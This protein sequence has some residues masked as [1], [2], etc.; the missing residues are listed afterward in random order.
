MTSLYLGTVASKNDVYEIHA[1]T[2][3]TPFRKFTI[4]EIA[5]KTLYHKMLEGRFSLL[6]NGIPIY[7][8]AINPDF[9]RKIEENPHD[10]REGTIHILAITSKGDI[11]ASLSVAIDT[12]EKIGG[13]QIG[14]PL[15]NIF[16]P[17]KYPEGASLQPFRKS[18]LRKIYN[19]NTDIHPWMMAELYR[20]Y[21]LTP[22][23]EIAPRLGVYTGWYH[24]GVRWARKAGLTPTTLWVFDAIPPYFYLYKLIGKAVLRD[25]VIDNPTRFVSPRL[26][27]LKQTEIKG[28]NVILYNGK[29]ISRPLKTFIPQKNS[30]GWTYRYEDVPF[31]DGL[32]DT[33]QLE[34]DA[35]FNRI[36]TR[37]DGRV[38]FDLREKI[39]IRLGQSLVGKRTFEDIYGPNNLLNELIY[40]L[41]LKTTNI[42]L[43]NFNDIG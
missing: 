26:R 20:H 33:E 11:A 14:L 42:S 6:A 38:G 13:K 24:L 9:K 28:E 35:R 18:Y 36:L 34:S 22:R 17:G 30:S 39:K 19:Q 15:E 43:W 29:K 10:D 27:E 32:V 2:K 41:A 1:V 12:H 16:K 8:T 5:D 31:I 4:K 25:W 21:K 37:Y 7:C 23:G 40:K 3:D